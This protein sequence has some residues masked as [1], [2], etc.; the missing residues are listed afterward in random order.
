MKNKKLFI[1]VPVI[2]LV[3]LLVAVYVYFNNEDANSFTAS[4]RKWLEENSNIRENFEVIT[5]YPIYGENG[6]FYEFINSLEKTTNLTIIHISKTGKYKDT[7]IDK[8]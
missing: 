8:E 5:D 4:E 6:I 3:V 7:I 2:I 1:L